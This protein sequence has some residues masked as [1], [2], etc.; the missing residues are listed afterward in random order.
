MN[1]FRTP[2]MRYMYDSCIAQA[3][4]PDSE[5]YRSPNGIRMVRRSGASHRNSFW[6]GLDGIRPAWIETGTLGYAAWRAGQ[7]YRKEIQDTGEQP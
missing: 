7:D 5:F 4:N 6:A 1:R 3:R 2:A